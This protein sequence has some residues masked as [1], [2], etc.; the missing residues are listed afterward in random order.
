MHNL[1]ILAFVLTTLGACTI[2]DEGGTTGTGSDDFTYCRP[3][4]IDSNHDGVADG[5]DV[6]CDGVIDF[7]YGGGG[8][9]GGGGGQNQCSTMTN[10]NGDT[11]AIK[12]TSSNGGQATC[13]CRVNGQLEQTCTEPTTRCSIGVPNGNCCG[14]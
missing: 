3:Q 4:Q 9:G 1:T 10:N 14:F 6:N 7:S 11:E 12:C 2:G 5:L 13:E 8:G